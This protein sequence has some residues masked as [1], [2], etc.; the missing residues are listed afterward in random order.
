MSEPGTA[1][2]VPALADP[3]VPGAD[4]PETIYGSDTG[5]FVTIPWWVVERVSSARAV[6]V[7]AVLAKHA[8][9]AGKAF[10]S[11]RVIANLLG[12]SVDTVD[13]AIETL[14]LHDA[15]VL[16]WRYADSE[17]RSNDY[18][19]MRSLPEHRK[20][21]RVPGRETAAP[22]GRKNA[23][24]KKNHH[25]L[26]P[27]NGGSGT[28]SGARSPA[29]EI[30]AYYVDTWKKTHGVDPPNEWKATLGAKAKRLIAQY[31]MDDIRK[32]INACANESKPPTALTAVLQDYYRDRKRGVA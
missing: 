17:Q 1:Q 14:L 16:D 27:P 28:A 30:V 3:S 5:P 12:C 22:P 29:Q 23:A 21:L 31:P 19:V 6:Q 11:R 15:L 24:Q 4:M 18:I 13:R 7:Y 9:R 10:P 8:D 32:A 20:M 2:T 26:E 25:E